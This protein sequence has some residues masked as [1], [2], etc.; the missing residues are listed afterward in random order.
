VT[1]LAPGMLLAV[2]VGGLLG[3]PARFAVDRVIAG[4]RPGVLPWGTFV[5]NVSGS[6]L[7]GLLVGLDSAGRLP[8]VVVAGAG[9]GFC[10]AFTTF[11]TFSF[12]LLGL[13]ER[14]ER[15]AAGAYL[16]LSLLAGVA[17]AAA[18]VAAGLVV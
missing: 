18:G 11:S 5:I 6:L 10:G 17:A 9:T 16:G 8:G 3:A 15:R 13:L 7:L 12:E 1:A 14:G 2:A 4:R